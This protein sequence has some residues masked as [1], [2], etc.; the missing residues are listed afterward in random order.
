MLSLP[1]PVRVYLVSVVKQ[2]RVEF[3]WFFERKRHRRL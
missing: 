2:N 1:L 3:S